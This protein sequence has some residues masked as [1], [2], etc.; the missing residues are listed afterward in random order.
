MRKIDEPHTFLRNLL[1]LFIP[2]N[3]SFCPFPFYLSFCSVRFTYLAFP[4]PLTPSPS[5]LPHPLQRQGQCPPTSFQVG[6]VPADPFDLRMYK[7]FSQRRS[8][9][10]RQQVF[11]RRRSNPPDG[12]PTIIMRKTSKFQIRVLTYMHL[13]FSVPVTKCNSWSG[14]PQHIRRAEMVH[15]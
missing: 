1:F 3:F 8:Y 12:G 13:V 15:T 9:S 5:P 6:K 2:V 7:S 4:P 11:S 10:P 14:D